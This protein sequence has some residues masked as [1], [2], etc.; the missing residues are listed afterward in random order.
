M[1]I[2][3][4]VSIGLLLCGDGM[5]VTMEIII[6][7]CITYHEN[8]LLICGVDT[9]FSIHC[10]VAVP[11]IS[12]PIP[13]TQIVGQSLTL[14]CSV[15]TVRGITSRVDIVWS[16]SD[17]ILETITGVNT[18]F[19]SDNITVY[20]SSYTVPQL[21]TADD[22][23]VYQCEVVINTSPLVMATG[24]VTLDVTVPTPT[25]SI[26][27]SGPIQGAM[28]GSPQDIQCTVSTVSGVELGSVMISWMGPGG[29]TITNDSRVT[30]SPTSGSGNNYTSSLQFMYLMEGDEGTYECNVMILETNASTATEMDALI[31]KLNI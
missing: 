11:S 14:E 4:L 31:S 19:S 18:N 26:T 6:P 8:Y 30:I 1:S 5:W 12:I 17:G 16:R 21:S 20:L 27:P 22:G 23:R 15:T 28:V 13:S 25:V 24:S 7:N 10:I 9:T 3:S 2:A 29:D